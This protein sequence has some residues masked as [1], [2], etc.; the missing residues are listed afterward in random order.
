LGW[1]HLGGTMRVELPRLEALA[2]EA[3]AS[4]LGKVVLLGMGGSSL[5][6]EV[7]T[8][9]FGVARGYLDLTVLDS[10]D[11]EQILRVER[12][13]SIGHTLFV[14]ASKSG[15]T[16]E[17][18][19]LYAHFRERLRAVVGDRWPR[20]FVAITDAGT[21]LEARAADEG[22]RAVYTNPRDI[23]GR[24][25]ALSLFGLLPAALLGADLERLLESARAMAVACRKDDLLVS[26]PGAALAAFLGGLA[27]QSEPARDKLT[28]AISPELS[29]LGDWIEQLV[30]ESTGKQGRGLL[31]V[32]NLPPAGV[33]ADDRMFVYLRLENGENAALDERIEW[34]V[35]EGHPV[36]VLP[37]RDRDA[38]GAE[39][40]R[41][42]VAIALT[43]ALLRVNP[44]DQPDVESAKK[45]ARAVLARHTQMPDMPAE[46]PTAAQGALALYGAEASP[47]GTLL[48]ALGGFLRQAQPGDYIALMAYA[49]RSPETVEALG[50]L[51]GMIEQHT[52]VATTVGFGPRFLHSTGQYHKGGAN[53][54]LFVQITRDVPQD[55]P[56]PGHAYT[57]GI[58]QQAQALGDLGALREGKR[59][60]VRL[61]VAGDLQAGL[62]ALRQ[63]LEATFAGAG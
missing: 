2:L 62:A 56:V 4:G 13:L 1:L 7:L 53:R 38:L 60:V 23:G 12:G 40:M 22:W 50:G 49:D 39:F 57:F 25:S 55:V 16:A 19:A 15:T 42:E 31:P 36:V 32:L 37:I 18:L 26:N 58:L 48:G 52:G 21:P 33:P 9:A 11:P 6:A 29:A 5:V 63:G 20:H 59:R 8:Q 43:G 3:Q 47:D 24:Y 61:H 27:T 44:F 35:K 10:T 54:G 28:L 41:W 45:G 17:P 34:L 46:T 14:V 51:R 30:A